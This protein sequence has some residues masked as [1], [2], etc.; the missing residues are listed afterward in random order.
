MID[1][2]TMPPSH[3]RTYRSSRPA[4]E[5]ISALVADARV[6]MRSNRPVWVT[7][8]EQEC[9]GRVVHNA[10]HSKTERRGVRGFGFGKLVCC[11]RSFKVTSIGDIATRQ[12]FWHPKRPRSQR[13]P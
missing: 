9:D 13:C 1:A 3:S 6:A 11:S 8:A 10:E 4:A 7:D 12:Y 2:Q 5:A